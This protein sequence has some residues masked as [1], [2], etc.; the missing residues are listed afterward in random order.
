MSRGS[1][2]FSGGTLALG[3]QGD[4]SALGMAGDGRLVLQGTTLT[5]ADLTSDPTTAAGEGETPGGCYGTKP[6]ASLRKLLA[7]GLA[8]LLSLAVLLG[9]A[10]IGRA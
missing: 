7:D 5:A 2:P 3:G 8:A 1:T 4:G 9:S 6:M 10:M